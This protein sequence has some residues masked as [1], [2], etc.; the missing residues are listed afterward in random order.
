MN[1]LLAHTP[2]HILCAA[3][4][5]QHLKIYANT[6]LAAPR[7]GHLLPACNDAPPAKSKI[8]TRGP[9]NG[10]QGLERC[11]LLDF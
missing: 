1:P 10:Q 4:L 5:N 9:Q 7:R 11:V 2:H 8:A 6:S 3:F